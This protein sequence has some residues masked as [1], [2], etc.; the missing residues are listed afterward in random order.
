METMSGRRR[1][2]VF[3]AAGIASIPLLALGARFCPFGKH[4][5]TR[6]MLKEAGERAKRPATSFLIAGIDGR[7]YSF[8]EMTR[9]RPLAIVFI[10]DGCPCSDQAAPYFQRL[11]ELYE[12]HARVVGIID[13]DVEVARRWASDHKTCYPVLPDPKLEVI[14]AYGAKGSAYVALVAAGGK[15]ERI[16]PGYSGEMLRELGGRMAALAGVP[17]A[18]FETGEAPKHLFAGCRYHPVELAR[19]EAARD[20]GQ[21]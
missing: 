7:T 12:G 16:W 21:P 14:Q 5:V 10:K 8:E 13:G 3:L 1:R 4:T 17:E 11:Q 6:T 9:A 15:I 19:G 2:I 20:P 18:P